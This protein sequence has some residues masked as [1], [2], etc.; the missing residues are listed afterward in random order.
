MKCESLPDVD[1][2]VGGAP[3]QPWC[4]GGVLGGL[5]DGCGQ[6]A[7]SMVPVLRAMT[8]CFQLICRR[9]S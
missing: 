7:F 8:G 9:R 6:L 2:L 5:A 3:C 1:I 4:K